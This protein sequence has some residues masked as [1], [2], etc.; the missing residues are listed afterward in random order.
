M[1]VYDTLSCS[2]FLKHII[3]AQC[4]KQANNMAKKLTR[5]IKAILGMNYNNLRVGTNASVHKY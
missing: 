2:L 4:V 3:F 1:D 5:G